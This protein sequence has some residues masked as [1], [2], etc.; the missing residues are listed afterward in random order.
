MVG[1]KEKFASLRNP[2]LFIPTLYF[3]QGLPYTIIN[4]LSVYM[5][6]D[7][8]FPKETIG[9]T[10]VLMFVWAVKMFWGPLIDGTATKRK[11][12]LRMQFLIIGSIILS[13]IVLHLPFF[14]YYLMVVFFIA[15]FFSA[16]Y[17]IATDGY[18]MFALN[19]KDQAF[20]TGIR[21]TAYRLS[22]IFS[23]AVLVVLADQIS[24]NTGDKYFGWSVSLGI[25]AVIF[26]VFL[27]YH[28]F[29]LPKPIKDKPS[30]SKNGFPFI[31][32]FKE[33]FT[34]K[35]I[36]IIILF[37]LTYRLGEGLLAK[38]VV[39]FLKEDVSLGGM[40][41]GLKTVAIM[42]GTFGIIALILG[43]ILGGWILKYHN[44]KKLIFPMALAMNIPNILYVYL[45]YVQPI[46]EWSID[47]TA[48]NSIFGGGEYLFTFNPYVQGCILVENFGYGFGF[49]AFMVYLLNISKG[50]FKTSF[51]AIS[52]GLMA[53]GV[54]IPGIASGYFAA[55]YG[56]KTLFILS[57]LLTIPG[58]IVIFFLPYREENGEE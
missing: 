52:T 30:S 13:A 20:F 42:N 34:Q 2:W 5:L 1:M 57:V 7:L 23:A 14:I 54:M 58:M 27:L 40:G 28:I 6:V 47:L 41:I 21:N 26:F 50:K 43:G 22:K 15:S 32:V 36:L 35:N 19:H 4:D 16:S 33:Y 53:V 49:S 48:I 25:A 29:I 17:D 3:V 39:P 11:W 51:Y 9:W 38:M 56:Y 37:I 12:I 44:L 55:N 18:Y 10:S 24:K 8:G 46:A 45:S 31:T